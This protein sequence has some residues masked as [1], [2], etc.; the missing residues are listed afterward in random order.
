MLISSVITTCSNRLQRLLFQHSRNIAQ[1]YDPI[2]YMLTIQNAKEKQVRQGT[3]SSVSPQLL[4]PFLNP[5]FF[6]CPLPPPP[7]FFSQRLSD[8]KLQSH[9]NC[10]SVGTQDK[11]I[12][13]P[14]KRSSHV[15]LQ[16]QQKPNNAQSI[17]EKGEKN[18]QKLQ[19]V[20]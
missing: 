16:F 12:L 20:V 9:V 5:S 18:P 8:S 11:Y 13:V 6:F 3:Q 1:G 4:S 7:L 17:C 14:I 10:R 15:N 2:I 19:D